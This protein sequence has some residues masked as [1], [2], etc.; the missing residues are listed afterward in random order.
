MSKILVLGAGGPAGVNTCRAL[1]AAGHTI[2]AADDNE[3]HLVWAENWAEELRMTPHVDEIDDLECDFVIAQPDSL[4]MRLADAVEMGVVITPTFLPNRRTIALC[5]NKW[6]AGLDF[7]RHNLRRD[8]L[9]FAEEPD[10]VF[11]IGRSLGFPY[12]LRARHGAGARAALLAR[13]HQEARDWIGFWQRREPKMEFI[14][15][16]HLPG[17]DLAWSSIW[18]EGELVTSFLRE[19]VEYLYPHLTMTGLTGTPTIARIVH[20]DIA[21]GVA[22]AAVMAVTD[23]YSPPHGIFSVDMVEDENGVP[24]P[25]E[26]NAGRGF[27]TFGLWSLFDPN[28]NFLAACVT[29]ELMALKPDFPLFDALPEGLTLS[30]HID[31]QAAFTLSGVAQYA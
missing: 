7:R 5:Q 17:R 14:A 31:C 2:V 11:S 26:V 19:R 28:T 4:V 25:T 15:E 16:A 20:D 30:R 10:A 13:D 18:Y 21:N 29:L 24:R 6:E 27:T 9:W 23:E 22:K 3:W 12:W 1:H 8:L